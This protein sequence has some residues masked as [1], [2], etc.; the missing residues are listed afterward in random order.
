MSEY[1][2]NSEYQ[3]ISKLAVVATAVSIVGL[4]GLLAPAMSLIS[5][6][7][8]ILGA[9]SLWQIKRSDGALSGARLARFSL[10]ISFIVIGNAVG[11]HFTKLNRASVEARKKAEIFF[12]Y[13]A[14][15]KRK[16]AH[17]LMLPVE[18]RVPQGA[19]ME[20]YYQQMRGAT[21][22]QLDMEGS[23]EDADVSRFAEYLESG[24]RPEFVRTLAS[25]AQGNAYNIDLEYK[26]PKDGSRFLLT[27]CRMYRPETR[28]SN[29]NFVKVRWKKNE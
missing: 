17:Q 6:F 10:I 7:A 5:A 14:D 20:L 4:L 24:Q 25:T 28:Q 15:G 16:L 27:M 3:Y 12:G 11:Y 2:P 1:D 8:I 9:F 13:V 23:F 22:P 29:W 18:Q 21:T 19:D 26:I